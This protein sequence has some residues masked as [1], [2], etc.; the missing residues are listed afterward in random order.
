M[1]DHIDIDTAK[2][3]AAPSG[4]PSAT[5]FATP[6]NGPPGVLET[7][8]LERA[9]E[10][11]LGQWNR[12]VSTTNWDKGRIICRWRAA[13]I[14]AGAPVH[15]Y[16]DEAWSRRVGNVSGQHVGRLRRC[17]E[18]F[19]KVRTDYPGLYWSHFQAALD[20]DDAEMWLE[21]AVRSGWSVAEMRQ[22]RSAAWGDV[23]S[24][25]AA[26]E[27]VVEEF[28][29]DAAEPAA[30]ADESLPASRSRVRNLEADEEPDRGAA[31]DFE[32]GPSADWGDESAAG[33]AEDPPCDDRTPAATPVRPFEQLP[34]LPE[35]LADA[36]E[37]MKLAI[38]RH[39]VAEW[40]DVSLDDVLTA[41]DALRQLATAPAEA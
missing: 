38:L 4:N 15:E 30:P 20:W 2:A 7:P 18:R 10:E 13:L 28:D 32:A 8:E 1:D 25:P 27:A 40:Q 11:F 6:P 21:G 17:F 35:D 14:D 9:S 36:V 31:A 41:L 23:E 3:A 29:E 26:E 37:S 33:T 19:G 16:S 12:L 24:G 39:K 22:Q 5:D 34:T